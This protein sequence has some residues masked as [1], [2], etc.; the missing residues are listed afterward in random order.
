M[1]KFS[2]ITPTY[3]TPKEVLA[4]TFASLKAQ[5]FT[6]WEWVI[7]DDS[8]DPE[9]W[10]HIYGLCSDERYSIRAHRSMTHSGR[11]GKVK[12]NGFMVAN[13][14]YLVELDHDDELTPD[15]LEKIAHAADDGAPD[16]IFSNWCEKFSNGT[17]GRYPEGW[18]L[19]YGRDRWNEK[20]QAWELEIPIMNND[21]MRHIVGVPNHVRVWKSS[22]Y[23]SIGGHDSNLDVCDDYDLIIRTYLSGTNYHIPELL[24]IQH[25]GNTT[26]RKKNARIQELVPVIYQK[27]AQL[28]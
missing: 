27:Y 4:R 24:Y 21:T 6:D 14:E 19:G 26:Q 10:A 18:G 1:P 3:N 12:R 9:T 23:H 28:L 11:I 20:L 5:T 25:I 7:W 2:I 22:F 17:T 16:F 13:G 8:T 15:A